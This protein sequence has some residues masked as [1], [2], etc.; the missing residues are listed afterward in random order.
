MPVTDVWEVAEMVLNN[1]GWRKIT[2]EMDKL[3]H[4]I[5]KFDD[6]ELGGTLT[7]VDADER[8][9]F[10]YSMNTHPRSGEFSQ[11]VHDGADKLIAKASGQTIWWVPDPCGEW[12]SVEFFFGD[13]PII[14]EKLK[15][16]LATLK[17]IGRQRR[18]QAYRDAIGPAIAAEIGEKFG[19]KG[20][21]GLYP[22]YVRPDGMVLKFCGEAFYQNASPKRN[23]VCLELAGENVRFFNNRQEIDE[24][25]ATLPPLVVPVGR[26]VW[27]DNKILFVLESEISPELAA[28]LDLLNSLPER[29][30][31]LVTLELPHMRSEKKWRQYVNP[32]TG[33]DLAGR[34]AKR[35]EACYLSYGYQNT[36]K[37]AFPFVDA[38]SVVRGEK[39]LAIVGQLRVSPPVCYGPNEIRVELLQIHQRLVDTVEAIPA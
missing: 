18:K 26:T 7:G 1:R 15:H 38:V 24:F 31:G 22:E 2:P 16:K 5:Y 36:V 8:D 33:V 10:D 32:I 28:D 4:S 11:M 3:I 17:T 35:K 25:L 13:E 21:G 34:V 6:D 29:I 9:M 19:I 20:N 37:R 39:V 30:C 23:T 27:I 12:T 14:V